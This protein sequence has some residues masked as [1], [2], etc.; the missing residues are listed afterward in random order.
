MIRGCVGK[1]LFC[2]GCRRL[3]F[4]VKVGQRERDIR[5]VGERLDGEHAGVTLRPGGGIARGKIPQQPQSPFADDP[6]G[7]FGDDAEHAADRAGF[8]A[9]RV[10]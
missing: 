4:V 9:Y 2:A 10:V 8:D 3:Q 7:R 1:S 6:F 5:L